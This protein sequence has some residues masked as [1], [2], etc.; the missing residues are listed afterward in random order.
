[1]KKRRKMVEIHWVP[2][3]MSIDENERTDQVAKE[4]AE[5]V[6]TRRCLE[7]FASLAHAGHTISERIWKKA[8]Q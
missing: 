2:V 5:N 8:K 1:M 7:R 6:G 4:T 3:H